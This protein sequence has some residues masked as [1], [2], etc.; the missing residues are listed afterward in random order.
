[1]NTS[2][3]RRVR[4]GVSSSRPQGQGMTEYII[5]V[6][7]VA[8]AAIGVYSLLGQT[9]RNQTAGIAQEIAGN[10]GGSAISAASSNANSARLTANSAKGLRNFNEDNRQ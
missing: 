4:H 10:D 1:M 6:A 8:V 3:I 2:W 7:V 9:I 5:V